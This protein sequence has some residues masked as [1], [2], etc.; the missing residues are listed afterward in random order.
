MVQILEFRFLH[1]TQNKYG[2]IYINKGCE[3]CGKRMHYMVDISSKLDKV[4]KL[5]QRGKYFV[6]NLNIIF[7]YYIEKG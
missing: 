5:V 7:N 3:S 6:I 4:L 2:K 1:L